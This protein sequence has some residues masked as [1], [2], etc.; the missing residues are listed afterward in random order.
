M[1]ES[2]IADFEKTANLKATECSLKTKLEELNKKVK[3]SHLTFDNLAKVVEL[4]TKIPVSRLTTAESK[5]LLNLETNINKKIIG[6]E[7]AVHAL[8]NAILRKRSNL[9]ATVRPPSFIFVGLQ[10]LVKQ[11]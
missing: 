1:A 8:S 6:Q 2:D 5:K 3:K 11:L 7:A 9:Q 10:V 4:W